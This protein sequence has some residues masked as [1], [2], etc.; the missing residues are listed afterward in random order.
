MI[1][2][3]TMTAREIA[4]AIKV[5]PRTKKFVLRDEYGF[6]IRD[7]S[8]HYA[9]VLAALSR[10]DMS[11]LP[12][13]IHTVAYALRKCMVSGRMNAESENRIARY[14][15]YQL[16]ALVA[17]IS[18]ECPE[19]TIGGICDGWLIRNHTSL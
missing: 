12:S 1:A 19:T 7:E 11:D 3:D 16:C 18:E 10:S 17:R 15:P 6:E 4:K 8:R 13:R 14:T 5:G 9:K 2:T